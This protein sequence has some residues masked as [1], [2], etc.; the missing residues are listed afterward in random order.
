M[1]AILVTG[2]LVTIF[3]FLV[4][5]GRQEHFQ[6]DYEEAI[7]DVEGRLEWAKTRTLFPFGM[8]VISDSY[9]SP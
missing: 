2:F 5:F 8:Q 9:N 3:Y 1:N 6:E 4:Q 7:K